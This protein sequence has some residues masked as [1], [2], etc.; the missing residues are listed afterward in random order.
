MKRWID[1]ER[2]SEENSQT[3][4][5]NRDLGE[6]SHRQLIF[7]F[8]KGLI[9]SMATSEAAEHTIIAGMLPA[10]SLISLSFISNFLRIQLLNILSLK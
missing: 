10:R 4:Y 5:E 9:N 8:I 1:S 6:S 7:D 3:I 2:M